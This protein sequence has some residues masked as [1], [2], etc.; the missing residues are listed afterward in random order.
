M[1]MGMGWE[2]V[3]KDVEGG[4]WQS[5]LRGKESSP[6]ALVPQGLNRAEPREEK[7]LCRM[8]RA[9]H[10]DDADDDSLLL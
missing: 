4:A 8:K 7:A 3:R 9:N 1:G 5:G 10:R 2:R 6:E